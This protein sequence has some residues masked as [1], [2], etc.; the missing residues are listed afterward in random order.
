MFLISILQGFFVGA[1]LI[2]AIG[3]QNAFV[4]N[5][6]LK[7]QHVFLTALICSLSDAILV[8]AG[9]F[10]VGAVFVSHPLL[11][12]IARWFGAIFLTG[13][14]ILSF[15]AAFDPDTLKQEALSKPAVDVKKIVILLLTLS[16]LNPH[17]Y[18]D[19]VVLIGSI[20]AQ[21]KGI[22]RPLFGLGAIIASFVWFF[23]IAYGARVLTPLFKKTIAWR[24]LDILI[25][26]I[27]W[28]IALMLVFYH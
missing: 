18:L 20:A 2:V 11:I 13:Y 3:P 16:F 12:E 19:T 10:G 9:V 17:A 1:G 4:I 6:G 14:G 23:S 27:M 5:Q 24:V 21:H 25:G 22:G 8:S 7:R 26:C 28:S 15:K